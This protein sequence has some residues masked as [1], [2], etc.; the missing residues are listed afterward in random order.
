MP[1][2][3]VS[4]WSRCCSTPGTCWSRTRGTFELV[5]RL[6]AQ[7]VTLPAAA[8]RGARLRDHRGARH[9]R[10]RAV[11]LPRQRGACPLGGAA[12]GARSRRRAAARRAAGDR[13]QRRRR[14]LVPAVR[15]VLGR[16][17]APGDARG[18]GRRG[19]RRLPH[20]RFH[21]DER[22]LRAVAAGPGH[23][24]AAAARARG[25]RGLGRR[26][27]AAG[28]LRRD[29]LGQRPLPGGSP[30]LTGPG[31]RLLRARRGAARARLAPGLAAAVLRRAKRR[32]ADHRR[33]P[34]GLLRV[35]PAHPARASPGVHGR[36]P[37]NRFP[38]RRVRRD[39]EAGSDD[40][41]R[42]RRTSNPVPGTPRFP[43]SSSRPPRSSR[44]SSFIRH[45]QHRLRTVAAVAALVGVLSVGWVTDFRYKGFRSN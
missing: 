34:R 7:F 26:L 14:P 30:G 6:I 19:G 15:A 24:V 11:H 13:R 16:A 5:P 43:S 35:G 21:H 39:P 44:S 1:R 9:D 2:T 40:N 22:R 12:T 4:S 33:N 38:G 28:A 18:D 20:R 41:A 10:M 32:H 31:A 29:Q 45:R 23:R 25:D 27:P 42:S 17:V 37:D 36:R 8:R 3:S